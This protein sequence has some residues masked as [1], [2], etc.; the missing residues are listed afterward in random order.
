MT[1]ALS[2]VQP[3]YRNPGM[4]AHQYALW[5]SYPAAL[6]AQIE[7]VLVDDGSPEPAAD[8]PRPAGLPPLRIYRVLE[9]RLW[10]QHGARNL[11][12]TVAA[13]SW[14][15]MTDMDHELPTASLEALLR[16]TASAGDRVF[17][18]HRLDAPN[19]TPKLLHGA[20]HPHQN[21][22]AVT[23]TRYWAAGG[24][25]E[26]L[27]GFYGTDGYF[28]RRMVIGA[29][30]VHLL[31]A[32]VVRYPREVIPDASTRADREA[33]RRPG[34]RQAVMSRRQPDVPPRVLQ[35]PWELAVSEVAR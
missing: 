4:L 12:A 19:L 16:A 24:Y 21:T 27:C 26:D 28:L 3:Y 8:V 22:F 1:P 33:G 9:D 25:D 6:K 31:D 11:G 13:S 30:I 7:I 15:F 18:F 32:P 20:P 14:L 10:H 5:A 2:I 17:T 34:D 29:E 23:K 35:F